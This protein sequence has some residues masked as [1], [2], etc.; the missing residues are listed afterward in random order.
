MRRHSAR[1]VTDVRDTPNS[2]LTPSIAGGGR[3]LKAHM[4][5]RVI[6]CKGKSRSG[7]PVETGERGV[8]S[9]ARWTPPHVPSSSFVLHPSCPEESQTT[10]RP[11][12]S[13][14]LLH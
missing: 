12:S 10:L 5:Q 4:E 13:P 7:H 6:T 11:S 14:L 2:S 8:T 3:N 1:K 9:S